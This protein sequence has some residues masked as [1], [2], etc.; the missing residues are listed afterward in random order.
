MGLR[1][2]GVDMGMGTDTDMDVGVGVAAMP[3]I[4][5]RLQPAL[6]PVAVLG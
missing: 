2:E 6:Q 1:L 5:R 4:R 3:A